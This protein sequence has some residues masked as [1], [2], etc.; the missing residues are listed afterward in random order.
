MKKKDIWTK[1]VTST[2]RNFEYDEKGNT[3]KI[4]ETII[5]TQDIEDQ[6]ENEKAR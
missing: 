1:R 2:V 6:T 3:T 5:E 4:T